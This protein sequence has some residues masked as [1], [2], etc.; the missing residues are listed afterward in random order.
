MTVCTAASCDDKGEDKVV[1]CT[2]KRSGSALG[3]SETAFKNLEL[4]HGWRCLTS[5]SEADIN[6][7][8]RLY[9]VHFSDSKNLTH[10]K[11]ES[12][13]KYPLHERKRH[14]AD[15]YIQN[16]FAMS[17]AEFINSGKEKLP[18]DLFND[19][20][21]KIDAIPLG[22]E[23]IIVGFLGSVSE[24][25]STETNGRT[26]LATHFAI[27]GEGEYV[28]SSSLLRRKQHN[29]TSLECTIYN[30]YEAKRAAE[31]VGS[32]GRE[33]D[34]SILSKDG[35]LQYTSFGLDAQLKEMYKKYGPKPLPEQLKYKGEYY[36][37]E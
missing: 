15:D 29:W 31:T 7:L 20:L 17:Y 28:A 1:I 22:A 37:T 13:I 21:Q 14:I 4:K 24:I 35:S 10:A 18:S 9:E 33:T 12:I 34:I 25:Y 8:V 30:L 11:I 19:A 32:V 6:S 27:V 2:D 16:R 5:G 26:Q 3:S 36:F 23:L